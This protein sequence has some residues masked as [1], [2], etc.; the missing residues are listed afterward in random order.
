VVARLR[1]L[2]RSDGE[3]DDVVDDD[4]DDEDDDDDDEEDGGTTVLL[5]SEAAPTERINASSKSSL[6]N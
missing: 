6:G 4:D 3:M 1:R 5:A 2:A